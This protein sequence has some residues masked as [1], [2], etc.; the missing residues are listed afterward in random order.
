[1]AFQR[2]WRQRCHFARG[3]SFCSANKLRALSQ[4]WHHCCVS[5]YGHRCRILVRGG[6]VCG[7]DFCDRSGAVCPVRCWREAGY[8][9]FSACTV[10]AGEYCC[11]RWPVACCEPE[12]QCEPAAPPDDG[13]DQGPPEQVCE[14]GTQGGCC[15][16]KSGGCC[17]GRCACGCCQ[18]AE[19]DE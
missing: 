3:T 7:M 15:S 6:K 1:V 11:V 10:S 8:V 2:G 17:C 5:R 4:G 9:C 13:T 16:G 18:R 12:T 19:A 14:G